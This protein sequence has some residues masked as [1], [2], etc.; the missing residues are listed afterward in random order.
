MYTF[1]AGIQNWAGV[2]AGVFSWQ[3]RK[4]T[5]ERNTAYRNYLQNETLVNLYMAY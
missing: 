5:T 2:P 1:A 4:W 3:R